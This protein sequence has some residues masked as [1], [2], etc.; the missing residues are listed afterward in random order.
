MIPISLSLAGFLSYR[1]EVEVDF[2]GVELA[3]IS[4]ANGAGKSSILDGITFALFGQARSR[5][6]SLVNTHPEINQAEVVFVFEYENNRYKVQRIK[7]KE[8]AGIVEFH[9]QDSEGQWKPL[10]ERSIR[11][12]DSKIQEILR[13]DYETFVNAAF[14]LQG[15]ADQFTQ[16]RPG[17]RKRILSSILGLEIWETY[18]SR[19]AEKRRT[20]D[21]EITGLEGRIREINEELDE[22]EERRSKLASLEAELARL[23]TLRTTQRKVLEEARKQSAAVEQQKILIQTLSD[24]K[25]QFESD[26]A[27]LKKTRSDRE[28]ETNKFTELVQNRDQIQTDYR[29]L[30]NLQK[31]KSVLDRQSDEFIAEEKKLA[32]QALAIESEK[33]KLEGELGGLQKQA[34]QISHQIN[35]QKSLIKDT[36]EFAII[37][38]QLEQLQVKKEGFETAISQA[39]EDFARLSGENPLLKEEM[40]DLVAKIASI[41]SAKGTKC[42]TCGQPLTEEHRQEMSAIW[43]QEGKDKGDRWRNNKSALQEAQKNSESLGQDLESL[44]SNE[45]QLLDQKERNDRA[46]FE[47]SKI[48]N[49]INIWEKEGKIRLNNL[50]ESLK[51]KKFATLAQEEMEAIQAAMKVIGYDSKRHDEVRQ[52]I[53]S[54]GSI[55]NEYLLLERAEASLKPLEREMGELDKQVSK[56]EDTISELGDQH[57]QAMNTKLLDSNNEADLEQ[58]E[59]QQRE[60]LDSQNSLQQEVG[61]ASQLVAIL[62]TI[63]ERKKGF[64]S[65]RE[66]IAKQVGQLQILEK[67]FGKDG[68]PA[69]LIEQAL[70]QI[71]TAANEILERLSG[72]Q[73]HIRFVTQQAYKDKKRDDLRETLEIRIS[74]NQGVRDYE[75]FSGGEAFRINFAIRLALSEVLA[76]RAGARLQTLVIDEG[77]GSQD[78]IGRQRLIEAINLVKDDFAKILVITHI[79]ALKDAF[80]TRIEVEKGERGSTV[81]II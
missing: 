56:L 1:D 45:K 80:P 8:R 23:Q 28:N 40:D 79:E 26:L 73:M 17:D 49:E 10:S 61:A 57:S 9:I 24:Q 41:K 11:E 15:K 68:V 52:G 71:E 19:S 21:S 3:C 34:T 29:K 37:M 22:E 44:K 25:M 46:V 67:A 27:A 39:K 72:G 12:T 14:F 30:R 54:L 58:L 75:M 63:K 42:P 76:Q 18:K 74:D 20:F 36:K 62:K 78:E 35:K 50:E 66:E 69:M 38:N 70:P 77:F 2:Q 4:G 48:E 65:T 51:K 13:L 16:Q 32:V 31:E 5:D 47:L 55:E 59:R 43:T 81:R 60:L 7:S 6:N 53:K 64:E 33:S